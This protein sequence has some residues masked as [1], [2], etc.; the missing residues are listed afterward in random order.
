MAH[1]MRGLV[2]LCR[3]LLIVFFV[4]TPARSQFIE[5]DDVEMLQAVGAPV[6]A[7]SVEA[8]QVTQLIVKKTNAFREANE[9]PE[10]ETDS[11]LSAA[12]QD[13]ANYMARTDRYG[14]RADGKRPSERASNHGYSY[15]VV[16]ENIAYRYNSAGFQTKTLAETLVEGWKNSPEHRENMLQPAVRDT[17]V[18]VARSD[19]TGHW[20]A[21]QMFG[22]PKSAAIEFRISNESGT[23]VS[24]SIGP[25]E[26]QLPP[27]YS[28][29]HIRCRTSP[30]HFDFPDEN[31]ATDERVQP[32]S[33][34]RYAIVRAGDILR[35]QQEK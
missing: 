31:G 1:A 25:R 15:C 33:G 13:F 8:T 20:Y 17:G 32:Q 30:V 9:L 22:R 29:T 7:D 34:D 35:V 12:A 27:R 21:V 3:F 18:A 23:E 14:H 2:D 10:V 26:F 28:R 19:A 5:E 6:N 11:Q 4:T 24:Y 16:A